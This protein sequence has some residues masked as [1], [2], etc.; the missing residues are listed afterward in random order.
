MAFG[1]TRS[2]PVPEVPA[3]PPDTVAIR[4]WEAV[5]A[6]E[7]LDDERKAQALSRIFRDYTEA[8]LGIPAVAWTTTE[9]LGHLG[10][11]ANLPEGN[12][13]RARRLLRATDLVKFAEKKP[14]TDFFEDLDADLRAFVGS[15]RP[16]RWDEGGSDD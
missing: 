15:T 12:V 5:R 8:A 2:R 10:R 13:P 11:M 3:E 1:H 9:I 6:D 4:A 16:T 14:G 7:A